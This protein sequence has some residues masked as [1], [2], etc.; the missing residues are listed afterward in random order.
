MNYMG[1][2]KSSLAH[3]LSPCAVPCLLNSTWPEAIHSV[4]TAQESLRTLSS[5][6]DNVEEMMRASNS[7]AVLKQLE[8]L[9]S[10]RRN[11]A[12]VAPETNKSHAS[13]HES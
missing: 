8:D 12:Q 13:A 2:H 9:R 7:D 10:V 5:S 1:E 11:W 3:L 6:V 4:P